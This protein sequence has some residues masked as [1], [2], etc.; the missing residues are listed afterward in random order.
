MCVD[1]SYDMENDFAAIMFRCQ[2]I[3][4]DDDCV[5]SGVRLIVCLFP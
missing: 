1:E 4:D 3:N 5:P 2:R